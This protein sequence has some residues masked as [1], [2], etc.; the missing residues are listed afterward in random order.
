MN[1]ALSRNL[2]KNAFIEN[3][4]YISQV[5]PV[6]KKKL[7][8]ATFILVLLLSAAAG[9]CFINL[10]D[11]QPYIHGGVVPPKPDEIPPSVSVFYPENKTSYNTNNIT[12][13]FN[14]SMTAK[15]EYISEVTYNAD[16]LQNARY[17]Y[18]NY[19]YPND[20]NTSKDFS[21]NLTEIPEGSHSIIITATELGGFTES[22]GAGVPTAYWYFISGHSSV[23]FT[24]DLTPTSISILS[25]ENKI[26]NKR[27]IPLNLTVNEPISQIAYSLNGQKNVSIAGNTT[28]ADLADGEHSIT[29]YAWDLAGN[30]G[31]SETVFFSVKV[32]FPTTWLIAAV[33]VVA[34]FG[35]GVLVYL[36]KR[37]SKPKIS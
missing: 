34:V 27:D 32:P 25:L 22:T 7:L 1:C 12:L 24:I 4:G 21:L 3:K 15:G 19:P 31:A 11:A 23:F 2:D 8:K 35:T 13:A 37:K 9:A 20:F 29:V 6:K 26:Y 14:V 33:V 17:V 18:R 5:L 36:G 10:A 16:W 30:I 28:L